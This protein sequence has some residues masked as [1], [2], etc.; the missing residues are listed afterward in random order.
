MDKGTGA[1]QLKIPAIASTPYSERFAGRKPRI[2][3]GLV[4]YGQIDPDVLESWVTWAMYVGRNYG[5]K[6][7][8]YFGKATKKEQY[9]A[10]NFLIQQAREA[11]A[12]FLIMVDDDHLISDCPDLLADFFALEKPIQ[13]AVGAQRAKDGTSRPTV[14]RVDEN[15]HCDFYEAQ[16]LPDK[17]S[18]VDAAGGGCTWVDMWVFDFMAQPFW[19]PHPEA[20]EK[21]VFIPDTVHGLDIHF[22]IRAKKLLGLDTWLNTNVVL[23][24]MVNERDFIY[25]SNR[26]TGSNYARREEFR[27]AYKEVAEAICSAIPF[28]SALDVGSGQ[29]FLVDELLNNGKV[30]RGVE[31]EEGAVRYMS[32]R[33]REVIK[34]GNAA[35]GGCPDGVYDLVTCI[36]VAEHVPE[37]QE[38]GLLDNIASRARHYVYFTADQ[39]PSPLHI[40]LKP[41]EHWIGEFCKRGFEY[42]A[43][44]TDVV[45]SALGSTECPWIREN[46]MVFVR[47][48]G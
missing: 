27:P 18:V 24:H 28:D 36:E 38:A 19:W 26:M 3:I 20:G 40:N 13:C 29:G 41:K 22:C 39:T 4:A 45:K 8:L 31:L 12:D 34:I 43:R 5:D 9:R 11:G 30:V 23:G 37:E 15:G 33:A 14:L 35:N 44:T 16:E 42:D 17:P 32:P 47:D 21:V 2:F 25:P 46:S 48:N 1:A 6:F 10:R 7:E